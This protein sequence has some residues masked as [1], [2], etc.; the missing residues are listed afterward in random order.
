MKKEYYSKSGLWL[1]ITAVLVYV[2]TI[3]FMF[4]DE[5][6]TFVE[7][8]PFVGILLANTAML[9]LL[10]KELFSKEPILILEHSSLTYRGILKTHI[11]EY[12]DIVKV[13]RT[14]NGTR[15]KKQVNRIGIKLKDI[16]K[17]VY[18][19]VQS[20]DYNSEKLYKDIMQFVYKNK[21]HK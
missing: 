13:Q 12:R 14:Y 3:Y 21:S 15:N 20:I 8:L 11:I 5:I 17:P 10:G 9:I 4:N 16:D 7:Y 19:I 2:V 18:I 6:D 1:V